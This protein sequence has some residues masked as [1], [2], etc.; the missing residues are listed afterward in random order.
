[1]VQIF[2][3]TNVFLD[4]YRANLKQDIA[5][6]M[7]FLHRHKDHFIT[8]EQSVNEFVRNRYTILSAALENFKKQTT[9]DSGSSSFLRSLGAFGDY[10]RSLKEFQKQRDLII[11]EIQ[12]KI[13]NP[14]QDEISEKFKKLCTS[15]NTIPLTHALIDAASRRKLAGN[16]PTSNKYTCGDEIIWE[17]LLAYEA[18]HQADLIIVSKDKTFSGNSEFLR[19]EYFVRTG[20]TLAIYQDILEAYE[21]A[22]IPFTEEFLQA[23]EN[24]KWTDIIVTALTNLGGEATLA[25]IYNEANDILFYNNCKA[26]LQNKAKESTI[27]GILQRFSSDFPGVYNGKQDLFHQVS[28]GVRALR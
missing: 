11:E 16:P 4:M 2:I 18:K 28:E 19:Q 9:I 24:L 7:Q 15:E 10:D 25:E 23:A 5:K 1:M 13:S 22:G 14:D 17:S 20:K 12:N 27:R 8:T 3:D 21:K 6:V 26:K